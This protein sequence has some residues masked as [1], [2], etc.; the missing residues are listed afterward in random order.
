LIKIFP[1]QLAAPLLERDP[2]WIQQWLPSATPKKRQ[3]EL[4]VSRVPTEGGSENAVERLQLENSS[5]YLGLSLGRTQW[6]GKVAG[7]SVALLK[8]EVYSKAMANR[9]INDGLFL[10][11]IYCRVRRYTPRGCR[12]GSIPPLF[13]GSETSEDEASTQPTLFTTTTETSQSSRPAK[14]PAEEQHQRRF[15]IGRPPNSKNKATIERE[16]RESAAATKMANWLKESTDSQ[17]AVL[18]PDQSPNQE[19]GRGQREESPE[20]EADSEITGS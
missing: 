1:Q 14:R 10:E 5:S 2:R 12:P 18:Y 20:G 11:G 17:E 9:L 6:L 8:T 4:V 7:N 3:Y 13:E 19:G 16:Q 15:L